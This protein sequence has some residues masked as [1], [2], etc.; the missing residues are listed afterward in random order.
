MTNQSTAASP[1]WRP[2]RPWNDLPALPPQAELETKAVL[3]KCIAARA[4][5]GELKQ[6]AELI[7]NQHM[8]INIIPLM[9]AK[10]S[11]EIENIVTT[12]DKLFQYADSPTENMDAAT[13]EALAY[14][15]AL[16][17]GFRSLAKRPLCTAT[18]MEICSTIK[19]LQMD[20]REVPGTALAN[21]T[22]KDI[23]YTPPEGEQRL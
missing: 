19:E 21:Q 4:A 17:N 15:T 18:A 16:N 14:R 3:K 7:P 6:A 13:R 10:D 2:D 5:L 8:L 23:I 22:T 9:E 11:C 20:I 12:T 1:E